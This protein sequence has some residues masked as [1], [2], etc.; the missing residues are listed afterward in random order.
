MLAGGSDASNDDPYATAPAPGHDWVDTGPH[1]MIL[2]GVDMM[3]GLPRIADNP[4]V[5]YV[6][7]GDTPYAHVMMPVAEP[8]AQTGGMPASPV[9]P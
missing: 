5:P 9:K 2:S 6:M 3:Q 8:A 4:R 1:V 7:W